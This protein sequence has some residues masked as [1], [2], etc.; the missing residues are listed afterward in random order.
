M[1]SILEQN[2]DLTLREILPKIQGKLVG[3]ATTYFE[4]PT[5]KNPMDFWVY[6]EIITKLRPDVIVEIGNFHGGSTLALAHLCDLMNHGRVIG[7]DIDHNNLHPN[8]LI[9][10]RISFV[11]GDAVSVEPAVT[12]MINTNERTMIIE[13]SS[14]TFENTLS[15]LRAYA[16]LVKPGDYFIIEDSICHHGL[17]I[18]PNPGAFEAIKLFTQENKAFEIDLS[19][20]DYIITWNPIGFLKRVDF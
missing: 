4:I 17:N 19:R 7:V 10:P 20:E 1:I 15:V 3:G 18:G 11:T 12:S 8:S 2:L 9:H 14:H 5:Q 13:D 16:H 6:Q